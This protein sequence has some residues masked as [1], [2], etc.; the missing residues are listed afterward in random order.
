MRDLL[1]LAIF[2]STLPFALVHTYIGVLLWNWISLMNPHKLAFGF[3]FDAPF[4]AVA[5]G[6]TL[7]SLV[8]DRK[9]LK[10]PTDPP[11]IVLFCFVLWM[12]FTSVVG[13]DWAGSVDQLS[14]VLKIQLMTFVAFAAIRSRRQIELFI[15]VAVISIGFFGLKGG[16]FTILTGGSARVWGPPGGFIEGNNEL[17]VALVMTI[18]LMN[19]LRL[20][21]R[22]RLVRLGLLGLQL[23]SAAAALGTQSRGALLAISAMTV[24]LWVR[25][26]RKF[27]SGI[28]LA[29]VAASLVAFMPSS[30]ESR[31]RTIET[32]EKDGSATER[33]EA[34]KMCFNLAND[35]PIGGGFGIY[36][37][38]TYAKYN[39]ESP[40]PQAAHS[41]YFSV[42]GE[43]GWV[44]LAMFLSLGILTYRIAG[45][46]RRET[47]KIPE[48]SWAY[49][50]AGMCQVSIIGYAVGGAFLSLAYFDFAYNL[51]VVVVAIRHWV[52]ER[53]WERETEGAFGSG[54]PMGGKALADRRKREAPA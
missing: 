24:V 39:P 35:R 6:A 21:S 20:A 3:A 19:Y 7:I 32:Y 15:W 42:L 41:I 37:W 23:L 1:I 34:W 5:A 8:I 4:A 28:V 2:A 52:A 51:I 43:H 31:M 9:N 14:K 29:A 48:A 40:L 12:V 50:L 27:L 17:A 53:G 11:V 18:P 10:M 26:T 30:W 49:Y 22:Q 47:K 45:G 13:F 54:D 25:G 36:T 46:I 33:L 44:G 38:E 16:V